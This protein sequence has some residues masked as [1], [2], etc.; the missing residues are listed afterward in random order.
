MEILK[1]PS[2]PFVILFNL[3]KVVPFGLFVMTSLTLFYIFWT[4]IILDFSQ[5]LKLII[6]LYITANLNNA[7]N[8][9]TYGKLKYINIHT[10]HAYNTYRKLKYINF[11]SVESS[12]L[13]FYNGIQIETHNKVIIHHKLYI[14]IE[15]MF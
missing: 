2:S 11:T 3:S 13:L 9:N 8:L 14:G 6:I 1:G 4:T 7:V 5:N 12:K 15:K 10:V